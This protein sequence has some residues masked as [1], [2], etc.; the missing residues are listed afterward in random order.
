MVPTMVHEEELNIS[1]IS[2][3]NATAATGER[4]TVKLLRRATMRE[5]GV[6]LRGR[7]LLSRFGGSSPQVV[8]NWNEADESD[9]TC[10]V[11]DEDLGASASS[12][13]TT[14]DGDDQVRD[15]NSSQEAFTKKVQLCRECQS[16]PF[17]SLCL[18]L[19]LT[20]QPSFSSTCWTTG[21][22]RVDTPA[23]CETTAM[24]CGVMRDDIK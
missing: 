11:V 16:S 5:R 14:A 18:T 9:G 19:C 6:S 15:P 22:G 8:D 21:D 1:T 12:W 13:L 2:E 23:L 3:G 7:P 10:S 24:R 4:S 20:L 17:S